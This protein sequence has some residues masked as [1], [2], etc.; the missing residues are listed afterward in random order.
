M[1]FIGCLSINFDWRVESKARPV[2][3]IHQYQEEE[4]DEGRRELRM[5]HAERMLD[6]NAKT[7]EYMADVAVK[8]KALDEHVGRLL[9]YSDK[10]PR[11]SRRLKLL[12]RKQ[13]Q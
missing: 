6:T 10:L 7:L 4:A 11:Q 8:Q 9:A 12:A 5:Q 13:E 3:T 2:I 1:V